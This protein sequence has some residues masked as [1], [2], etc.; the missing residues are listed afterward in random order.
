MTKLSASMLKMKLNAA[1]R[2]SL[3]NVIMRDALL[4]RSD[5]L[6]ADM[7]K[8]LADLR[9]RTYGKTPQA[10]AANRKKM[11]EFT[12]LAKHLSNKGIDVPHGSVGERDY[13][14]RLNL[15]GRQAT[16]YFKDFYSAKHTVDFDGEFLDSDLP[17]KDADTKAL[18]V[19]HLMGSASLTLVEGDPL[20]T[21]FW[22]LNSE[23]EEIKAASEELELTIT[24]MLKATTLG[25]ALEKWAMLEEY[26]PLI[27]SQSK[28]IVVRPDV[29]NAR[30][31]AL[32]SGKGS[33]KSAISKGAE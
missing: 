28:E 22:A 1:N 12:A 16:V 9:E 14:L 19:Y 29:L 15:A 7:V 5:K 8:L 26:A 24:P 20:N 21:R 25:K 2:K 11:N 6:R 33:A 13:D 3:I 4:G 23:A 10:R 30:I 27:M 31:K 18:R 32:K 17:Y